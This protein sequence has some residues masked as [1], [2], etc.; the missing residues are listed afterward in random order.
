MSVTGSPRVYRCETHAGGTCEVITGATL[1]AL[2][3]PEPRW[4]SALK[5]S[6]FH[7]ACSDQPTGRLALVFELMECNIYELIKGRTTYLKE[8]AVRGYMYQLLKAVDHMHRNGIFH[9]DLKPENLLIGPDGVLKVAD[10]GSCRG[11]YSKQPYTEYISTRWYRAPECLLTDGMYGHKMDVWGIGCVMFEVLALFPLFPGTNETDQIDRIHKVLGTPEPSVL[12]RLK[13]VGS[14]HVDFSFPPHKRHPLGLAKLAPHLSSDVV[15]LMHKLLIYDPE[16]RISAREALKHPWFAKCRAAE[17]REHEERKARRAAEAEA[18][19]AAPGGGGQA[20][21][22]GTPATED[23]DVTMG[24]ASLGRQASHAVTSAGEPH[25]FPR[26]G[27]AHD[28]TSARSLS[29]FV[30]AQHDSPTGTLDTI[31][32]EDGSS[33]GSGGGSG[34]GAV[35]AVPSAATF[36]VAARRG[37]IGGGADVVMGNTGY[38][39]S[40]GSTSHAGEAAAPTTGYRQALGAKAASL[41]VAGH[42]TGSSST[43]S[44]GDDQLRPGPMAGYQHHPYQQADNHSSAGAATSAMAALLKANTVSGM[45]YQ[46]QQQQQPGSFKSGPTGYYSN[47]DAAA[48]FLAATGALGG[49]NAGG[50]PAAGAGALYRSSSLTGSVDISSAATSAASTA[51]TTFSEAK[52]LGH[53]QHDRQHGQLQGAQAQAA[54]PAALA[55][56]VTRTIPA[57][58]S[59]ER[60]QQQPAAFYAQQQGAAPQPAARRRPAPAAACAYTSDAM[61]VE[62]APPA[63][64]TT[65]TALA[66][67]STTA[68]RRRLSELS[69]SGSLPRGAG[70]P[71]GGTY[72]L[73]ANA[74]AAGA[75]GRQ[76]SY[77]HHQRRSSNEA[78]SAAAVTL[79]SLATSSGGNG[80]R[81][82]QQQQ[83]NGRRAMGPQQSLAVASVAPVAIARG[84]AGDPQEAAWAAYPDAAA[85]SRRGSVGTSVDSILGGGTGAPFGPL[86]QP[87]RSKPGSTVEVLERGPGGPMP[88]GGRGRGQGSGTLPLGITGQGAG[89]GATTTTYQGGGGVRKRSTDPYDRRGGGPPDRGRQEGLAASGRSA[90]QGQAVPQYAP[91]A[92]QQHAAYPQQQQHQQHQQQGYRPGQQAQQQR[93]LD[94]APSHMPYV[95]PY[96]SAS[97][98]QGGAGR[99]GAQG[100]Y[101]QQQ[102]QQASFVPTVAGG[103]GH[104][105]ADRDRGDRQRSLSVEPPRGQH[106]ATTGSGGQQYQQQQQQRSRPRPHEPVPPNLQMP[107]GARRGLDM[108]QQQQYLGR[109]PAS[110][111]PVDD[112][113][114]STGGGFGPSLSELQ[115]G[116]LVGGSH[117]AR[118]GAQA[119]G[120]AVI[121]GTGAR[122]AATGGGRYPLAGVGGSALAVAT[123]VSG[124]GGPGPGAQATFSYGSVPGSMQQ[125]LQTS[126]RSGAWR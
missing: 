110:L 107:P 57:S 18:A 84:R 88:G 29:S 67:V 24:G 41:S 38:A 36:G 43:H 58:L 68:A 50:A 19:G 92:Y 33:S 119:G 9:R 109:V 4:H 118:G 80:Q 94:L 64:F 59:P 103:Y 126:G 12:D 93:P 48:K 95:S 82:A 78:A 86:V 75:I 71:P 35:P 87:Q 39:H 125:Q 85:A 63:H 113:G 121:S 83:R 74:A 123:G 17:R 112:A 102:Q 13:K 11:I 23:G 69:D 55:G 14:S 99:G 120:L 15:D 104:T 54:A 56:A 66:S 25:P 27:P 31:S 5:I 122:A 98:H 46:Q 91:H 116:H 124:P 100:P 62:H 114:S 45:P 90:L 97:G 89:A 21:A 47:S 22:V 79:A 108:L 105:A 96:A 8:E 40:G 3:L 72:G 60:R 7:R 101:H 115:S 28:S 30:T 65:T 32:P 61:Q 49:G 44:L 26:A 10:F 70:G 16:E 106:D 34:A 20:S 76:E 6:F 117:A 81:R 37:S 51:E 1:P 2:L 111:S 53:G 73:Q 52:P 42:H 77:G